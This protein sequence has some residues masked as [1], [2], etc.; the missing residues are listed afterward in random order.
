MPEYRRAFEPGGTFFFTLVTQE[1]YSILTGR[2]S[3]EILR[4]AFAGVRQRHPFSL[5]AVVILPNHLH[6]LWRLPDDDPDFSTRWRLIKAR[7]S[8]EY[9]RGGGAEKRPDPRRVRKGERGIWQH[10]FWEHLVRNEKEYEIL[11]D[12]IHY[13][14]VR[15]GYADCPHAWP[16]SSF[17][18]FVQSKRYAADWN[19]RCVPGKIL[20]GDIGVDAEITGE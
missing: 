9:L 7:F 6:C 12:Y 13:N 5:D 19:C 14:P 17:S 3:I 18:K 10:R 8:H 4:E 16:Y 2:L 20:P 1:R 11:C 15:H